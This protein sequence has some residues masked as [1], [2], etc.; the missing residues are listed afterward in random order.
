VTD[1]SKKF[2]FVSPCSDKQ[3]FYRSLMAPALGCLRLVGFMKGRGYFAEYYDPNVRN[4]S[5]TV[6]TFEEKLAEH[7]WDFIGFSLLEETLEND[8]KN[9][10]LAHMIQPNA[11]LIAGGIEAQFNYQT[12][13]DKSPCEIVITGE[14]EIPMLMLAEGQP[15]G[16]IP[17]IIFKNNAK[18]LSQELFDEATGA[19]DWES[20]NYEDYWD[21]YSGLYGDNMQAENNEEIHTVRLFS[22]NRCPI[23]C[24]FCSSTGQLTLATGGNVPV[25]SASHDTLLSVVDR[26]VESHP[27]VST[28]YLTDDDFCINKRD[29]M[30][31]CEKVIERGYDDLKFM[32]FARATDITEELL[33]WMYRANFRR[34]NIGVE[35]YSQRILDEMNKRCRV[36]QIHNALALVKKSGI[37]AFTNI[38]MTTPETRIEDIDVTVTEALKY[39]TQDFCDGSAILAIRPLGGTEFANM[40]WDY[41]SYM[42]HVE[43]IDGRSLGDKSFYLKKD[44]FIWSYDPIVREIQERYNEGLGAVLDK[45][46][47]DQNLVHQ[48]SR[49]IVAVKLGY[50]KQLVEEAKERHGL[51]T[52]IAAAE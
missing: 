36:D 46:A 22:R 17:G 1:S 26:I 13:L 10:H 28:I 21:F 34:L 4:V 41:N 49:R 30:R 12:V 9:I 11:K 42:R 47:E 27:R 14:G 52:T 24:K 18:A 44:D 39:V 16:D 31:F 20:I 8:L 6:P 23:A 43:E 37:K 38:I 19:I 50:M 40:H 45:H 33:D 2:L 48:T 29:V 25:I 3:N 5:D 15:I 7:E 51:N 32:C 35:S